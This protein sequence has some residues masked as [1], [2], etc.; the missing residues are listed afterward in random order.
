MK[1]KIDLK[2]ISKAF[3]QYPLDIV[4]D[5]ATMGFENYDKNE[6]LRAGYIQAMK[7]ILNGK[8]LFKIFETG[9][10]VKDELCGETTSIEYFGE[11]MLDKIEL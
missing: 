5:D 9:L 11:K 1:K 7:D 8:M 4:P 3:E 10:K 6:L 2:I